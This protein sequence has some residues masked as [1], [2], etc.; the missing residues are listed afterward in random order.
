MNVL[1][2]TAEGNA[3]TEVPAKFVTEFEARGWIRV[4]EETAD[5]EA[6]EKARKG[7]KA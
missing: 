5:E 2:K 7:K 4:T 3:Y 1:M 6:A